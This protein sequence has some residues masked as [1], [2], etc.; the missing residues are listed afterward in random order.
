MQKTGVNTAQDM[1]G[2]RGWVA[3][4]NTNLWGDTAPVDRWEGAIWPMGAA[5]L[6]THLWQHYLFTNNKEFLSKTA[7][8]L[9]KGAV[10]FFL[11]YLILSPNG[12]WL[13]GPSISPENRFIANNQKSATQ[14]MEATMDRAILHELFTACI[15]IGKE[16]KLDSGFQ[17]QVI[18][19]RKKLIPYKIG[20]YGQLQEWSK[21]YEE[22]E[23]GHR[24]M[25]HLWGLHPG[26]EITPEKTPNFA[27]A[28]KISLLRRLANGGGH[29]GWSCAWIINFWA[30]LLEP[31]FAKAYISTILT[32][33]TLP[34][35]FDNH[36]PFQIDGNFGSTAGI[37]E[38]LL[39][40]HDGYL[41]LLPTVPSSWKDGEIK[42]LRARGNYEI[43]MKWRNCHLISASIISYSSGSCKI[44]SKESFD[45]Y[46]ADQKQILSRKIDNLVQF[47][48]E[49]GKSYVL[50]I[51]I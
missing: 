9:I 16:L 35:L 17:N 45:I 4:H 32:K 22:V 6:C 43:D 29:T 10:E 1:Y 41:H 8:P 38:M 24:H 21:D 19:A 31:E 34:N 11:D 25:S 7:Y 44:R 46:D 12:T 28:C 26:S 23:P 18:D 14:T 37:A 42:G 39:Q 3:H 2:C 49:K 51:Q 15:E 47:E 27:K 48:A 40:S 20:K 30:R 36:P 33:S 5:W 13:C 50:K